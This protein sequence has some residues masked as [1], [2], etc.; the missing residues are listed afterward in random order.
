MIRACLLALSFAALLDAQAELSTVT[1][2]ISDS[3]QAVVP[4]VNVTIRNTDT[5][6]ARS[7]VS[8]EE[9]Y[10]TI[11]NLPPGPYELTATKSGFQVWRESRIVLATGQT[12]RTD[13]L[14][15]VGSVNESINVQAEP[16][17]LNTE[18]GAVVGDVIV[19]QEID[20]LPLNGRDFT[21]LAFLVPG[22]M[23][24]AQG[25]AGSAMAINGARGDNTNFTVDG[26]DDRNSR[27]AAAQLRP[28]ID[29]LEEFQMLVG[30]FSA[31]LGKMA[32][33]NLSMTLKSGTNR[34][35]GTLF[36]YFRNDVFDARAH[37]DAGRLP[38]HQNQFGGVVSGPVRLPRYDGHDRTFFML[39]MESYR[40]VAGQ[41]RIGNVA[42]APERGGD[43]SQSINNAGAHI[44]V[45]DPAN[46][47]APFPGDVIPAGRFSPVALNL[48]KYYPLPNRPSLTNNYQATA[49]NISNW[50]SFI[51][52]V[53]QR[54]S[55]SDS[56]SLTYGKRFGRNNAPWAGS[57]LGE[58]ANWVQDDRSLGGLTYT[59]VFTPSL[60]N[61]GR[62]GFSRNSSREH[63]I[64]GGVD[65]ASQTGMRGSTTDPM[66]EG[67]PLVNIT[68][69]LSIG[70]ANNE[71]V[72]YFV[73]DYQAGDKLTWI[74]GK[75]VVR[76]GVDVSRTQFNQPF[77][78]NSRG[79]MTANGVWTGAGNATNGDAF[80]DLLLG[81]LNS[82]TITRNITRNYLRYNS[83]GAFV[84]NDYKIT[85]SLTLNLGLRY[86]IDQPPRD[87]YD[88][89]LNFVPALNK[90]V[91]ASADTIPNF[92]ALV[93]Q[94]SLT[95]RVALAKD[96]GLPRSLVYANYKNFAP[97]MGF[98]WRPFGTQRMVLRGGYGIFYSGTVLNDVRLGLGTSFPFST[99][100][101]FSRNATDLT[102][103]TVSDPWPEARAA[104]A[105]TNT[106]T[107]FQL[108]APIG[109]L[110]SYNLTVERELGHRT[111]LTIAYVGSKGT[112][113]GRQYNINFPFRTIANYMANGT[114]FPVPYWPLSTINY[115][116]FGSNSIY[117]A[118][119][120]TLTKRAFGGS[121]VSV[122]YIYSKSIDNASQLSGAST[123]GFNGALDARN[124]GLERA[125]SDWDRGHAANVRF[126]Y[127]VPVGP[128]RR[129]LAGAGKVIDGFLGGWQLS[130]TAQAATG[131][132]F[133]VEDSNA[134]QGIGESIRPNRLAKGYETGGTGRRGIDYPWFNPAAFVSVPG[135]ASR[136]NCPPD[137]Y[138]FVP[139]APGNSGRNILDGP[140]LF[141]INTSM[142]KNFAAGE[143]K[144]F[145]FRYEVFNI[146]NHQN[147][148]LPNRN[149]NEVAAGIINGVQDSGRG[150]PRLM[151]FALKFYF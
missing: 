119:Q 94:A 107:G 49:N 123:G 102:A 41:T 11:P 98:A 23:P 84:T 9:G 67:M 76:F 132:P 75:H 52:K 93:E 70:Y 28:N 39:S 77:F 78:N 131:Q 51:T 113:L 126:S 112:H 57:N 10:F 17:I 106:S 128:G 88:R 66:L 44:I 139:F 53:D 6:I 64:G 3:G 127:Q 36:E 22:V 115:W 5:N 121:L 105:G 86:E 96:Y 72:Q 12:L 59:H 104:L 110:Q 138:G 8:N 133:T 97:R 21:D 37:F 48:L 114:N 47:N 108:H 87:K 34:Y 89:M 65:T 58:F 27:G 15:Q 62:V 4:G 130:G 122:S 82:S 111:V 56:L 136:T 26:F 95:G 151:Q 1:G 143:G 79:T 30:G 55:I 7:I 18:Q 90:I 99:N 117:N 125:R 45:K 33:G 60:I 129:F 43:F 32:G 144:R 145:Q 103:L 61:E 116:D 50:D 13:V 149:F 147:F 42:T 19:H 2:V 25:G 73:T 80:G 38:L 92:D 135:C 150:G 141:Y 16:A 20:E 137:P 85:R 100:L 35:H 71:P 31:D 69:F 148:L 24:N 124:L 46:K 74:R 140:R 118:G 63:I 81:L 91:I 120:A 146:L 68:G 83:Y 142:I 109:Y 29:A 134:N 14:L 101:M 40:N 54:F